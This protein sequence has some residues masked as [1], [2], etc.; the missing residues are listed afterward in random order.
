MEIGKYIAKRRCQLKL[1]MDDLAKE[2]GVSKATIQRWESGEI[3]NIRHEKIIR[4]AT[5]LKTS[6]ARLIGWDEKSQTPALSNIDLLNDKGLQ[7]VQSY[8][9]DLILIDKY[10]K[11]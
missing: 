5:A 2:I 8:V 7:R 3:K 6:P 10:K 9:D 1:T 11:E 4:I